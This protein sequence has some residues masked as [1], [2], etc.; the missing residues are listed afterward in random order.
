[1]LTVS[2]STGDAQCCGLHVCAGF[3]LWH[4]SSVLRV[5]V[6]V[7]GINNIWKLNSFAIITVVPEH[8]QIHSNDQM[9]VTKRN[10]NHG[11]EMLVKKSISL[12]E[13][14]LPRV[15]WAMF[16]FLVLIST[17]IFPRSLSPS[18]WYR[19]L[20]CVQ[21]HLYTLKQIWSLVWLKQLQNRGTVIAAKTIISRG[22][23]GFCFVFW[24]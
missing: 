19:V 8:C 5:R 16:A 18:C 11:K 7:A 6:N 10:Y 12:S 9:V 20:C 3:C 14:S 1:M 21:M 24:C 22:L 17:C 15:H 4:L 2:E 13:V 23:F